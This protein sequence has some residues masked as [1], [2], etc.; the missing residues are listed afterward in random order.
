M[1]VPDGD[2]NPCAGPK[3]L[4]FERSAKPVVELMKAPAPVR[5]RWRSQRNPTVVTRRSFRKK[6]CRVAL[7]VRVSVRW[8]AP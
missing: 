1:T 8:R 3:M 7:K 4:V 5:E 2:T 6:L